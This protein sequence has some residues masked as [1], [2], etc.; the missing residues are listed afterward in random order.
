MIHYYALV[1]SSFEIFKYLVSINKFEII[2]KK[3]YY[4]FE[5]I[6]VGNIDAVKYLISH[7]LDISIKDRNVLYIYILIMF[8]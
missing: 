3:S 2:S 8:F 6:K 1:N 5:L 4:T 7:G